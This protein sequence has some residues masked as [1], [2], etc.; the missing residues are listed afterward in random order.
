VYVCDVCCHGDW[1]QQ[2]SWQQLQ[3]SQAEVSSQLQCLTEE[4]TVMQTAKDQVCLVC[5]DLP[6]SLGIALVLCIPYQITVTRER[7]NT[8]D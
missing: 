7:V 6:K 1:Q 8:I 4:M 2:S 5:Y 3:S